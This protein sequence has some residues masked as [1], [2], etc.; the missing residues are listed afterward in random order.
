MLRLMGDE[1]ST[2][3][4]TLGEPAQRC[5]QTGVSGRAGMAGGLLHGASSGGPVPLGG[6]A[7]SAPHGGSDHEGATFSGGSDLRP[8]LPT[9]DLA[10][11]DCLHQALHHLLRLILDAFFVYLPIS[12]KPAF[13]QSIAAI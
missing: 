9:P 3:T 4:M 12:A 7:V 1:E 11:L 13:M 6:P 5:L 2:M 10:E 8:S